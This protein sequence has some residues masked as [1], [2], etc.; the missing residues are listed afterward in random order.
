MQPTRVLI[1]DD[2]ALFAEALA[3]RLGREP[4]LVPLPVAAD[5]RRALALAATEGPDVVLLDLV[6]GAESGLDVLDRLRERHPRVRVVVLTA[7]DDLDA[8]V[9]AVRRGAVGWLSKT[10]GA[11]LVAQVVRSA[12]RSGGWLP[13]AV[14]GEVL[15]RLRAGEP[16]PNGG[17]RR[18]AELTPREREVLQCM[19][20]GLNRAEIAERLGLSANTVRTH[21]QNLLAKLGM[22]SALEAIT[23]AMRAGM[24]PSA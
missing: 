20:D 15:R 5:A 14:L 21:T 12:A 2:H 23:L 7:S 16:E 9:Q 18:L 10:E 19:V 24:R 8:M 13:P 6:L 1:V 3:A 11:G 22:H 17:A 4:D